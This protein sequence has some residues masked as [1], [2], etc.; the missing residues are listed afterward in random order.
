MT[1]NAVLLLQKYYFGLFSIH[2]KKGDKKA[3][4]L[5]AVYI[6]KS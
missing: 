6:Y 4:Y 1:V 2:H 5:F 3:T